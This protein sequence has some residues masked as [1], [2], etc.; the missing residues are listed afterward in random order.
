MRQLDR[1]LIAAFAAS[2]NVKWTREDER[3]IKVVVGDGR[4][5]N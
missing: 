1:R 3:E 2:I 4:C 5:D